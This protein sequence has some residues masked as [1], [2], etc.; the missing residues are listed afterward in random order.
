MY[1]HIGVDTVGVFGAL[2]ISIESDVLVFSAGMSGVS[3]YLPFCSSR[4][5][6]INIACPNDGFGELLGHSYTR[7]WTEGYE[8]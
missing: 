8:K 6:V 3:S 7:L 5:L 1:V 4:R 2:S